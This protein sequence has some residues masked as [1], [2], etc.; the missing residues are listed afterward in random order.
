M[1]SLISHPHI[2]IAGDRP[3]SPHSLLL[4][5]TPLYVIRVQKEITDGR[6]HSVWH[7]LSLSD[8]NAIIVYMVF[9]VLQYVANA[10]TLQI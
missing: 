4:G 3:P 6:H 5:L 7:A 2:F 9:S 8:E 1:D 10:L